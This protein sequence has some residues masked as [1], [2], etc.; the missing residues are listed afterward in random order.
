[1]KAAILLLCIMIAFV[2]FCFPL[3]LYSQKLQHTK[4]LPVKESKSAGN[5]DYYVV[6][7][8]GNGGRQ[9]LVQSV[10]SYLNLMNISVLTINTKLYLLLE[11]RPAQIACDL[12]N[13]MDRYTKKWGQKKIIFIGYS[14]GAEVLPFAFNCMEENYTDKISDLILIGPG[15]KVTFKIKLRDYYINVNKGADL[16]PEIVKMKKGYVICDDNEFSICRQLLDGFIDHDFLGGGHHF[17][18]D[19]KALSRL[20]GKRLN[21]K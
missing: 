3:P 14:M 20:I 5:S 2:E 16:Y 1:M 9:H 11:K 19:Y 12:E 10:T 21:L 17:G 13:L 7:M 6:L 8:T 15:Q 18:G 4:N